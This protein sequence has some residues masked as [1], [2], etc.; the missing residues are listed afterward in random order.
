MYQVWSET[1]INVGVEGFKLK[2]IPWG[3]GCGYFLEQ[4]IKVK[5]LPNTSKL[6]Y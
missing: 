5:D 2:C 1:V 3:R 4:D 6:L